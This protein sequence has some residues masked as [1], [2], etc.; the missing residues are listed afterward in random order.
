MEDFRGT[1][2]FDSKWLWAVNVARSCLPYRFYD[3]HQAR[4]DVERLEAQKKF[5]RKNHNALNFSLSDGS[6]AQ[7]ILQ[8]YFTFSI[9]SF[10]NVFSV[11]SVQGLP[12]LIFAI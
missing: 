8:I 6:P 7:L 2:F 1:I 5:P 11:P 4:S 9:T 3:K 10:G 12:I